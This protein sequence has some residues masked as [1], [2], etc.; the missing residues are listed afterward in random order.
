MGIDE[1]HA[2]LDACKQCREHPFD[3]CVVGGRLLVEAAGPSRPF[4]MSGRIASEPVPQNIPIRTELG[5]QIREAFTGPPGSVSMAT[6]YSAIEMRVAAQI[7]EPQL[8]A[9][10]GLHATET[11]GKFICAECGCETNTSMEKPCR[12]CNSARVVLRSVIEQ[13]FGENWR[14]CFKEPK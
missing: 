12:M 5:K 4:S 8:R 14:D 2:H 13:T 11:E 1:F 9:L 10:A 3:L 7:S 6:N